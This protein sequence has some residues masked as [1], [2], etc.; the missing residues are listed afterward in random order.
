VQALGLT[1]AD[2]DRRT[3]MI[4][5]DYQLARDGTRTPLKTNESRRAIDIPP[6]L[7]RR[8]V[9]RVE[10]RGDLFTKNAFVFASRNGTGLERKTARAALQRAATAAEL[11]AP[12]PTL[13]D[14]RHTHASMLIHLDISLV[15][16]QRRLG[17]RKPDTT[18]RIYAHQWK[19][20]E[21]QR[22]EIGKQLGDLFAGNTSSSAV[23][24]V[25]DEAP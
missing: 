20:R 6:L 11:D 8:L 18:L 13:H 2:L 1:V 14:L 23:L 25:K 24:E 15:D 5:I 17:H 19:Y 16:I 21:A 3:S 9:E 7:M 12:H 4:R 10:Q 22:S